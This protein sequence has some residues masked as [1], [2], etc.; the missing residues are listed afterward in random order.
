MEKLL[1]L[2]V[3]CLLLVCIFF[4][5]CLT[6]FSLFPVKSEKAYK[7]FFAAC[8]GNDFSKI[9]K[10]L[11][12]GLD[13]NSEKFEYPPF[14]RVAIEGDID[15][16]KL[17]LKYNVNINVQND[18][19]DTALHASIWQD[20]EDIFDILIKNGADINIRGMEE[21]TPLMLTSSFC[22]TKMFNKLIENGA[23]INL[24]DNDGMT[25]LHWACF[26]GCEYSVRKLI[27]LGSDVNSIDKK[28]RTPLFYGIISESQS[29]VNLLIKSKCNLK[30]KDSFGYS[31]LSLAKELEDR[32]IYELIKREIEH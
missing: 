17:F 32:T 16:V 10:Y 11:K 9:K 5:S 23:K 27:S 24:S 8:R 15:I 25:A 13:P 21:G 1:K 4:C 26:K 6:R 2:N 3:F 14:L 22:R 7:D 28:G 19:G 30:L 31:P 29:S 18:L 20:N 12:R